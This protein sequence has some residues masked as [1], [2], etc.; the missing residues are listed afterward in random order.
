MEEIFGT[1]INQRQLIAL[2]VKF[3][4]APSPIQPI[5]FSSNIPTT[6]IGSFTAV[7]V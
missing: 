4:H 5:L 2:L 1:K 3:L 7:T 6:A